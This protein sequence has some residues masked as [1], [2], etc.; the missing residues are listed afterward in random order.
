MESSSKKFRAK[1]LSVKIKAYESI[2]KPTVLY[3]SE[4]WIMTK[5]EETKLEIWERNI[6]RKIFGGVKGAGGTWRRR[7]NKEIMKIDKEPKILWKV[8]ADS[9]G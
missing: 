4:T 6:P 1:N 2:I 7:S 3:A 8:W 9:D 5:R